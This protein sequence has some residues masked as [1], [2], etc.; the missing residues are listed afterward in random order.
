VRSDQETQ[1]NSY[2]VEKW[3]WKFDALFSLTSLSDA[4][5]TLRVQRGQELP[6]MTADGFNPMQD[7]AR[8]AREE[9]YYA[10]FRQRAQEYAK[11]FVR[12]P[13]DLAFVTT[14]SSPALNDLDVMINLAGQQG[15]TLQLVI[16]PYHAQILAMFEQ[17]GLWPG[18]ESWKELLA[19]K[20]GEAQKKYP[21]MQIE[22]WDFSGFSAYQCEPIPAKNDRHASTQWYWEAGHF[23]EGP[24]RSDD[25]ALAVFRECIGQRRSVTYS[26]WFSLKQREPA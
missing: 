10:I 22:L 2:P 8:Y 15:T 17:A 16:Y 26:I 5:T 24:G 11:T 1:S 20:V 4:L 3:Q 21:G 7:Y 14:G 6:A 13:H 12:K 19:N 25:D 23:Q 9:G 18:F